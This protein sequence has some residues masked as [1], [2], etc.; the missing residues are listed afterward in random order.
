MKTLLL[1]A[2]YSSTSSYYNDWFD[3]FLSDRDLE[4]DHL[5]ICKADPDDL[6]KKI[7]NYQLIILLHSTTADSLTYLA[8]FAPVLKNRNGIIGIFVGNEVNIPGASM[9]DKLNLIKEI[10]P[11]YI[12]TQLLQETGEWL[13]ESCD[14]SRV[15]SIPHALN[16]RAFYPINSHKSRSIF[17]GVRSFKY[18]VHIG[19]EER[20]VFFEKTLDRLTK[21]GLSCDISFDPTRRLNR[22]EWSKFLNNC[23]ITLATEA[24][25]YYLEKN[26]G[27]VKEIQQYL[28][29]KNSGNKIL[30]KDDGLLK[31]TYMKMPKQ[32]KEFVKYVY[33]KYNKFTNIRYENIL[34]DDIDFSLIYNDIIKHHRRCPF[35]SKAISSRQFDAIG[36]RTCLMMLEGRYNDILEPDIHYIEVK[37]DFSNL[38]EAIE[39]AQSEKIVEEITSR[40]YAY[41]LENHLHR[42][43]I[44]KIKN[45]IEKGPGG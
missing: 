2:N 38:D 40:T 44:D 26:D 9:Q 45:V 14:T 33:F 27:M 35:Y 16:D 34:D 24:G 43:R 7:G 12:F 31:K 11:E 23:K 15:I 39:K 22:S 13:Y 29:E 36:T 19:D 1:Y 28:L 18:G 41:V 5:D 10:S 17:A 6:K 30:V 4:C 3:A 42:H 21:I 8:N 37:K 20:T 32:I 25:S